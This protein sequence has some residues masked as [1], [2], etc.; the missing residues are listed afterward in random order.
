MG[1]LSRVFDRQKWRTKGLRARAT[2]GYARTEDF[3]PSVPSLHDARASITARVARAKPRT[4]DLQPPLSESPPPG[5][6]LSVLHDPLSHFL[7]AGQVTPQAPQFAASF[8]NRT[9]TPRQ[10]IDWLSHFGPTHMPP[11]QVAAPAHAAPHAPQLAASVCSSTQRPPHGT[12][13]AG[14]A[15]LPPTHVAPPVQVTPQPPQFV[16]LR[17]TSTHPLVHDIVAAG[18]VVSHVPALHT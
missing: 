16:G 6:L 18:H 1:I 9:Q 11:M 17:V 12:A 15:Q 14:H 5:P 7:P 2:S 4:R 8:M 10:R 3:V 13:P